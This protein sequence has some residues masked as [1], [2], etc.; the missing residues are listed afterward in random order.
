[1]VEIDS[2][3]GL[4]VVNVLE[5]THEWTQGE[6]IVNSGIGFQR[7][8]FSLD[9]ASGSPVFKVTLPDELYGESEVQVRCERLLGIDDEELPVVVVSHPAHI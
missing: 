2:G 5:S 4:P 8:C 3:I 6:V 9:S 1:M 7:P